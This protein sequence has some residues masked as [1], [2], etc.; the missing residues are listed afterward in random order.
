MTPLERPRD[1]AGNEIT[2]GPW[3]LATNRM[4]GIIGVGK[5]ALPIGSNEISFFINGTGHNPSCFTYVMYE[6]SP[7]GVL[8]GHTLVEH[9]GRCSHEDRV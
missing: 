5:F 9:Q 1:I 2:I 6:G 7:T 4:G 3:Y 8:V